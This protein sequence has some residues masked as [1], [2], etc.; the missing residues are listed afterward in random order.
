MTP[1]DDFTNADVRIYCDNDAAGPN[2]RWQLVPDLP[3]AGKKSRNSKQAFA[4]QTWWDQKNQIFRVKNSKGC[5]DGDS[6]Q[7]ETY[8][9]KDRNDKSGLNPG[10][11]TITVRCGL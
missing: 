4:D 8:K 10:R 6:V 2:E 11:E 9:I 3:Y 1:T 7:A 5:Q